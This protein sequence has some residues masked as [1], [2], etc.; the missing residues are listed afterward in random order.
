M[1]KGSNSET[2]IMV[3]G[4]VILKEPLEWQWDLENSQIL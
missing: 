2:I 3:L 1:K 4:F